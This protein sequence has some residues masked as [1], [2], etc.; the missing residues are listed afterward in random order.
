[1]KS[2]IYYYFSFPSFNSLYKKIKKRKSVR[3]QA[4]YSRETAGLRRHKMANYSLK[5][6]I[7][8]GFKTEPSQTNQ[9]NLI[10]Q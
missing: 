5:L 4:N 6:Q 8:G 1:M 7:F 9:V 3:S 2:F 10:Y